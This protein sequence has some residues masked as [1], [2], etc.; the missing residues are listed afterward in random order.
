[1]CANDPIGGE[2]SSLR[3]IVRQSIMNPRT[4]TLIRELVP[5]NWKLEVGFQARGR[6][7]LCF[8]QVRLPFHEL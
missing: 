6:L 4:T 3:L 5:R 2:I 8:L 7:V 1:M